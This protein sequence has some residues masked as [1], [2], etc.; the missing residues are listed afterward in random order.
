MVM[1]F[2]LFGLEVAEGQVVEFVS[3]TGQVISFVLLIWNQLGR[4]D[5]D[6]F[7]WKK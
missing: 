7:F 1:A 3:A 2:S 6:W 5:V 4:K